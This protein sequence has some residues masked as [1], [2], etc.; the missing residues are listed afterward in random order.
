MIFPCTNSQLQT[1]HS[2]N[3]PIYEGHHKGVSPLLK[4]NLDLVNQVPLDPMHL[5]YL[6]VMKKFLNIWISKDL[7]LNY[8]QKALTSCPINYL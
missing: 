3:E 5:V 8:Q 6:G 4:L 1:K 2:F 7:P